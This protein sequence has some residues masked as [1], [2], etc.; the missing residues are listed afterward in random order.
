MTKRKDTT[1]I[2]VWTPHKYLVA[3]ARKRWRYSPARNEALNKAK[4]SPAHWQCTQCQRVVTNIE[5][6]TKKGRVSKKVD[7]AI[8]HVIPVGKQPR[9]WDEYPDYYRRMFCPSSNLSFLCSTCHDLKSAK[10][11][12]SRK[13]E[14]KALKELV[15]HWPYLRMSDG[16]EYACRHGIGHSEGVH[17][18]DGCCSDPNF[19]KEK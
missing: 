17:G 13:L 6:I 9:D 7:G 2:K 1:K 15:W 11:R 10:E 19:P 8:D 3:D 4:T 14:R 5:Y 12:E 18:C 16:K